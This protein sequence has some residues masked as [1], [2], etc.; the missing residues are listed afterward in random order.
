MW[1][2]DVDFSCQLQAPAACSRVQAGTGLPWGSD[3]EGKPRGFHRKL[4]GL[5]EIF[6]QGRLP[7]IHRAGYQNWSRSH[8][9]GSDIWSPANPANST[10]GGWVGRYLAA[11]PS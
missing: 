10:E 3:P 1:A 11:L 9:Y 6:N 2:G 4:T 5:R 8:F 7:L